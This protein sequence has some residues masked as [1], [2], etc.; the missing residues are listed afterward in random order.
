MKLEY[1]YWQGKNGWLIGYLHIWP[2]RV[3]QGKT[4]EEL[5]EMLTNLYE[6]YNASVPKK[7]I[8]EV[9]SVGRTRKA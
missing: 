8:I 7:G 2:D 4:L 5:E 9:D 1:T 6:L 3:A